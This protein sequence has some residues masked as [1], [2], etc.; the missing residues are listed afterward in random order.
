MR[1]EVTTS[2]TPQEALAEALEHFGP[3]GAGLRLTAQTSQGLTFQGG[4]GHVALAV[5]SAAPTTL[6]LETREWD[7]AVQQFMAQVS[8]R[9]W[10]RRWWRRRRTVDAAPAAFTILN[11]TPAPRAKP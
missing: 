4:G 3:R 10:W 8:R 5:R 7:Y 6:E 2:L 11:N 9:R 1:Y